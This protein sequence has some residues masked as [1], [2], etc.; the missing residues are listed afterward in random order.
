MKFRKHLKKST[1]E[2][3]AQFGRMLEEEHVGWKDKLAMV[4]SA[5]LVIVGPIRLVLMGLI[6]VAFWLFGLL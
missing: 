3:E 5:Y 6:L 2:Q 4:L 1:P